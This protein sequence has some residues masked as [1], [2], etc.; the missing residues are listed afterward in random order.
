MDVDKKEVKKWGWLVSYTQLSVVT[1]VIKTV[2]FGG[3][4]DGS[5]LP[6]MGARVVEP[7]SKPP[8][9]ELLSLWE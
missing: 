4:C 6:R 7:A 2:I 8:R 3:N 1:S 9:F 5:S